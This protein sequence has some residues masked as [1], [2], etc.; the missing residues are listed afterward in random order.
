MKSP[1]FSRRGFRPAL[2]LI[3]LALV[4]TGCVGTRLG[5]SWPSLTLNEE[6]TAI[7]MAFSNFIVQID[8]RDGSELQLRNAEG[9][10][11]Y[12]NETGE[13][14]TWE[15]IGQSGQEFY[16]APIPYSDTT[17]LAASYNNKLLQV[18]SKAA[19]VDNP[20]GTTLR[21]QVLA[22]LVTDDTRIFVAYATR[23][24][25]A[26]DRDTLSSLW[27]VDTENG[28][29][30]TPT[31]FEGVLYFTSLDNHLYAVDSI[32][33]DVLWKTELGGAAAAT[34]IIVNDVIYV[35]SFGRRMFAISLQGEILAEV[36]T[37]N[38][39]WG[40]A[41]VEDGVVY[42]ADMSGTAY[43]VRTNTLETIWKVKAADNGIRAAPLVTDSFII[44]AARNGR[45]TW[46]N[47]SDGSEAFFRDLEAEILADI[48]LVE[49]S[50]SLALAEPLVVVST[51]ANDRLL[52][53]FTL[54]DG[55]RKWTYVR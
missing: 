16:S 40:E 11:R 53:A 39:V 22:D 15:F 54:R 45:V 51:V 25:E 50:E 26:L 41:V 1:L 12:N 55:G 19:R 27:Y 6:H 52:V 38:W 10:V 48:L 13:P 29:W 17:L 37:D 44:T 49:P 2:L 18:D 33:G 34:P 28:I 3:L 47:K 14:L 30:D 24:I 36:E 4:V 20:I 21:E 7:T 32:N 23:G 35:G 43:A 42:F 9:Q 46:L 8:P 5:T 31:L